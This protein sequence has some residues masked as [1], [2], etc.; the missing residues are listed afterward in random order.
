MS[1][2]KKIDSVEAFIKKTKNDYKRWDLGESPWLP[3]FRGEPTCD[4]PLLPK[5]YRGAYEDES[6]ENRLLQFF[7]MKAPSLGYG[8]DDIRL[9]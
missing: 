3:W 1:Q 7:R 8:R 9:A 5:L 6:Y 2:S 4:K